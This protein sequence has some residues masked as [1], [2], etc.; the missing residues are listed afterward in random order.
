VTAAL[1][2]IAGLSTAQAGWFQDFCERH[3]VAED[4]YQ[5]E[6]LTVEQLVSVYLRHRRERWTSKALRL[7]VERRLRGPLSYE[8]REAL[9]VCDFGPGGAQ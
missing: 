6:E 4:P 9:K 3:L 8:E 7:E 5:Y 2:L 1:V